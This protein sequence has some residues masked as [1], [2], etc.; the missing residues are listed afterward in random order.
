MKRD[1]PGRTH[2]LDHLPTSFVAGTRVYTPGGM[3]AIENLRSGDKVLGPGGRQ[4]LVRRVGLVALS[5]AMLETRP[6]A[7]P[8]R[9]RARALGHELPQA[10]LVLAPGTTVLIP[11]TGIGVPAWVL[12]NGVSIVRDP[13]GEEVRYH[14]VE[15]ET[16]A[17]LVTE[18]V[19]ADVA[20]TDALSTRM[21]RMRAQ[22]AAMAGIVPGA[23]EG[24]VDVC[25]HG[26]VSGWARDV[27]H[28][29]LPMALEVMVN[30]NC[31]ASIVA[32]QTRQDLMD[33]GKGACAFR[34][35]FSPK[36]RADR[37]QLISVRR[38]EGQAPLPG[39]DVML[40]ADRSIETALGVLQ[41][42]HLPALRTMIEAV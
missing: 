31:V 11:G 35:V 23:V 3:V 6:A 12:V 17:P 25:H 22:L 5:A 40:D 37:P 15:R 33:V 2:A 13:V 32:D 42:G 20:A 24:S 10:D 8:V 21:L 41:A 29:D 30:G 18:G 14:Q 36:L 38:V 9:I 26:A 16:S 4:Q 19:L 27:A 34:V 39:G 28:P 7:R 1:G